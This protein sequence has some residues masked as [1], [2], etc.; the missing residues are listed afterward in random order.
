MEKFSSDLAKHTYLAGGCVTCTPYEIGKFLNICS[1]SS[2]VPSFKITLPIPR[3]EQIQVLWEWTQLFSVFPFTFL[4]RVFGFMTETL[5]NCLVLKNLVKWIFKNG[6][7]IT[8]IWFYCFVY[9]YSKLLFPVLLIEPTLFWLW[10]HWD[11]A[12]R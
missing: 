3:G 9:V 12:K 4:V 2:C 10:H 5:K 11:L 7:V 1:K 6:S 8:L